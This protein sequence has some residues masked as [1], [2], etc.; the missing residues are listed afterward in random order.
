MELA[1]ERCTDGGKIT[2]RNATLRWAWGGGVAGVSAGPQWGMQTY[3]AAGAAAQGYATARSI[4]VR[5]LRVVPQMLSRPVTRA[6]SATHTRTR[7]RQRRT[8]T[9]EHACTSAKQ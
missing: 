1:L 8:G 5:S 3:L 4:L 6:S 9:H 7:T 2:R